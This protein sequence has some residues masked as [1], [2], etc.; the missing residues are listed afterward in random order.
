[1]TT[2]A[3]DS[4]ARMRVAESTASSLRCHATRRTPG[5]L[6]CPELTKAIHAAT[7]RKRRLTETAEN[8]MARQEQR[9]AD[10]CAPQRMNTTVLMD[11]E[12]LHRIRTG[13]GP[14]IARAHLNY[15]HAGI[16]GMADWFGG[17]KTV[18][19]ILP[20]GYPSH[21]PVD[22]FTM[23]SFADT[24]QCDFVCV[25]ATVAIVGALG[26]QYL[27]ENWQLEQTWETWGDLETQALDRA[28]TLRRL[29]R[30]L[31]AHS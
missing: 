4:L 19:R 23:V 20:R 13:Y 17:D 15:L 16:S 14:N 21:L 7:H 25:E 1:M 6:Q 9:R 26:A 8:L 10:M 28:G 5:Y 11:E 3:I 30:L 2:T 27:T 18:I 12:L 24:V 22:E 29:E 31:G